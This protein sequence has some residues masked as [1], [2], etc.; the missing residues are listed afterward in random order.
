MGPNSQNDVF[1][2]FVTCS[3]YRFPICCLD[4]NRVVPFEPG[5]VMPLNEDPV[6]D[7]AGAATI[8]HQL[9]L[10]SLLPPILVDPVDVCLKE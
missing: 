1:G 6:E 9:N 8:Q 10:V 2:V 7:G 5:H 4:S 3:F